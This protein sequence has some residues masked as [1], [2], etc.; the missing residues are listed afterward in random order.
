MSFFADPPLHG[1]P[2][3]AIRQLLAD[4]RNLRDLLAEVVPDLAGRFDF[5]R[6]EPVGQEFL[7]EDWRRREADL[8]FRI[9]FRE[10]EGPE[11]GS[12][13]VLPPALV[14]VLV[15]HQSAP[16]PRMPLRTLL[17]AVLYCER[18]WKAWEDNHPAGEPLRL[19]PVLPVVFHTGGDPWRANRELRDLFSGPDAFRIFAP[20]WAPLFW[21]LAEQS[22]EALLAETSAWLKALAVVRGER[23]VWEAFDGALR[24]TLRQLRAMDEGEAIR[25]H[26]LIWFVLSWAFRRRP[27]EEWPAIVEAARA[28][29][30][31]PALQEAMVEMSETIQETWEQWA[32]RTAAQRESCG[33]ARGEARG[34]AE[35]EAQGRTEEARRLTLRLLRAR[36]GDLPAALVARIEQADPEWCEDL[37]ERAQRVETVAELDPARA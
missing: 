23:E 12:E 15:E 1:F 5:E 34:K 9:P 17:Y 4:W 29:Q 33:E 2:D 26:D 24:A 30:T 35:G 19:S 13:G 11:S 25:R 7:M 31:D 18:E 21:D 37:A 10:A 6:A 28:S 14:C 16:D 8:F 20:G 22:P 32:M 36:F 3:R 27:R